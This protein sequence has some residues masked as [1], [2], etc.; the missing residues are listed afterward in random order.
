ME[1]LGETTI[2]NAS[3]SE[4]GGGAS[5]DNLLALRAVSSDTGGAASFAR[6]ANISSSIRAQT[7]D[8]DV[9]IIST[10]KLLWISRMAGISMVAR[11]YG[12]GGFTSTLTLE[13]P[14][15]FGNHFVPEGGLGVASP[16]WIVISHEDINSFWL[17]DTP[18]TIT[19]NFNLN[20]AGYFRVFALLPNP[21]FEIGN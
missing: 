9:P 5:E 1:W 17:F 19:A 6:P 20:V 11:G 16:N 13:S 4:S 14:S 12:A 18:M 7:M 21:S 15:D 2:I 3:C 8:Y 10:S